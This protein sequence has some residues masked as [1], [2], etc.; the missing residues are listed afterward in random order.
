MNSV[1]AYI[2]ANVTEWDVHILIEGKW[3]HIGIDT[4]KQVHSVT[5]FSCEYKLRGSLLMQNLPQE[6][7]LA[8]FGF[9]ICLGYDINKVGPVIR[10]VC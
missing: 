8:T 4:N 10:V 7:Q 9:W 5:P 3:F 1:H 2:N 6:G